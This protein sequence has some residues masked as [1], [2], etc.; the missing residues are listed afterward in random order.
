MENPAAACRE[1]AF[2][3]PF[4]R[5]VGD[6]APFLSST[7]LSASPSRRARR[8]DAMIYHE[9][10]RMRSVSGAIYPVDVP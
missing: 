9:R 2:K 4:T 8:R 10:P 3:L 1:L 7:L 5:A 6:V